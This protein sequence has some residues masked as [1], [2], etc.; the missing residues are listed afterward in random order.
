MKQYQVFILAALAISIVLSSC[1]I[2]AEEIQ[3]GHD[4]CSFCKMNIVDKAH[5]AQ[6]VT[7]KGKQHKFDAIECMIRDLDKVENEPAISLVA[8]YGKPG[9]M[10]A[11]AEASYIISP[12]IK[13]PMGANLSAVSSI[14]KG[15]ALVEEY[16]GELFDWNRVRSK[17]L[18]K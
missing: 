8:D 3:Y 6:Y 9:T 16:T 11:A 1:R 14:E 4:Q 12:N 17:I 13:S 15:E 7:N 2:E 10:I 5:S 18:K